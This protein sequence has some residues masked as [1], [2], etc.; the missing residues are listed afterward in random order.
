M[1]FEI[2]NR[3][4]LSTNAMTLHDVLNPDVEGEQGTTLIP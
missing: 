4:L 1:I 2:F 3:P